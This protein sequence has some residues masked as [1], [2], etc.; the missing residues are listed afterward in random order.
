M[1]DTTPLINAF[2]RVLLALGLT[3]SE[4]QTVITRGFLAMLADRKKEP[5]P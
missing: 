1:S 4:A 2:E 5:T 3:A